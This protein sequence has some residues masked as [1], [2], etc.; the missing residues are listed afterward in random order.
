MIQ[1]TFTWFILMNYSWY[2]GFIIRPQCLLRHL[3]HIWDFI[4]TKCTLFCF[5]WLHILVFDYVVLL[6]F[7]RFVML[8]KIYFLFLGKSRTLVGNCNFTF[9]LWFMPCVHCFVFR[10]QHFGPQLCNCA[11]FF[12]HFAMLQTSSFLL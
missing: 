3:S 2:L 1:S 7:F 6:P 9:K 12:L 4:S 5:S 10:L 8:Q 11:T